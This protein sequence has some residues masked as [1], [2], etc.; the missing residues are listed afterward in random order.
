LGKSAQVGL[1]VWLA[2]AMEGLLIVCNSFKSC[3]ILFFCVLVFVLCKGVQTYFLA[4]NIQRAYSNK[5]K[6]PKKEA[7]FNDFE[8]GV[9]TGLML[10]DG[11]LRHSPYRL[12]NP[13]S[14]RNRRLEMFIRVD[15]FY[16]MS[17]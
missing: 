5:S 10:R 7:H 3:D 6:K 13:A 17:W 2:D 14:K 1:H 16:Y 4:F 15:V 11:H 9:M 8:M 12:K